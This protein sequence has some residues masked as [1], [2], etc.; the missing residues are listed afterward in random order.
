MAQPYFSLKPPKSAGRELF[1]TQAVARILATHPDV[2]GEDLV[3]TLTEFT[4]QSVAEACLRLVEPRVGGPIDRLVV[5]GGGAHNPVMVGEI[6][7]WLPHVEVLTQEDLGVS[8]DAKEAMA[9]AI[10]G[11]ETLHGRPSNVPSATGARSPAV[12]GTITPPPQGGP[13]PWHL[14]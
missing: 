9:F 6:A 3:R 13:L 5:G 8:S 4:A 14:G 1:G 2:P 11:N 7:R 12:L 10:L